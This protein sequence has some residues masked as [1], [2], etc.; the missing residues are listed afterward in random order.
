MGRKFKMDYTAITA[1]EINFVYPD[2]NEAVALATADDLPQVQTW[3]IDSGA[4]S[5]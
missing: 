5:T 4:S 1:K 3:I 2:A